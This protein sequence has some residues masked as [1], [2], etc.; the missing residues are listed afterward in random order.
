MPKLIPA[1][2]FETNP[3]R[4]WLCTFRTQRWARSKHSSTIKPWRG[5]L[6][7]SGMLLVMWVLRGGECGDVLR[8]CVLYSPGLC[9]R[10]IWRNRLSFPDRHVLNKG[11]GRRVDVGT[12]KVIICTNSSLQVPVPTQKNEQ[13]VNG[14]GTLNKWSQDFVFEREHSL[15]NEENLFLDVAVCQIIQTT[16]D[17]CLAEAS[18]THFLLT[19]SGTIWLKATVHKCD[20]DNYRNDY[21]NNRVH[22]IM[23]TKKQ[24]QALAG[25]VDCIQTRRLRHFLPPNNPFYLQI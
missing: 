21:S 8:T 5:N 18:R 17:A 10:R 3:G 19:A 2:V 20:M 6:S 4:P 23:V 12:F 16:K 9:E 7:G 24:L 14:R 15:I 13:G 25:P 1:D 22:F 11:H